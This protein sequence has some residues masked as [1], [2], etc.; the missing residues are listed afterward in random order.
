MARRPMPTTGAFSSGAALA[1]GG[2]VRQGLVTALGLA[3]FI[4]LAAG[5][6]K[7]PTGPDAH[8][9]SGPSFTALPVPFTAINSA[10]VIGNLG[11]PVHTIPT[12]HAGF[13]LV[14]TGITLSSPG[15]YRV[16]SLKA[17][18]YLV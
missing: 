18:H 10:T 1:P 2:D 12:D 13:Y 16:T 8:C 9:G 7:N 3:A 5:C 6:G 17:T 4:G 11:P 15:A 14:G